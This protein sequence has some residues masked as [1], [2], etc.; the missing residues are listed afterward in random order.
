M[1]KN[2]GYHLNHN[3]SYLIRNVTETEGIPA[4]L[5]SFIIFTHEI[6]IFVS[7]IFILLFYSPLA[8]LILL[9]TLLPTTLVFFVIIKK[10]SKKWGEERILNLGK[11][12]KNLQEGLRGIKDIKIF[13][14]ENEFQKN[15]NT[16]TKLMNIAEMKQYFIESLPRLWLEWLLVIAFLILISFSLIILDD[17]HDIFTLIVLFAMAGYRAM[18]SLVRILQSHQAINYIKPILNLVI[19]DLTEQEKYKNLHKLLTKV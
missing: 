10:K 6:L 14:K 15:F 7:L 4:Y 1:S 3:S 11:R 5:K 2:Y 8:T 9:G 16:N 12:F 17:K 19:N 18:P 13:K